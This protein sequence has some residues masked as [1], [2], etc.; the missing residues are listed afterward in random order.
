MYISTIFF[1]YEKLEILQGITE[2]V[3]W[4]TTQKSEKRILL[5]DDEFD[6]T[7]TLKQG[8]ED[9]GF[10]V[11]PFNDPLEALS[12]FRCGMYDL[13]L[14]DIRMP[15][16]NG[17]ELYRKLRKIDDKVKYCFMTA[18]EV[19]Y[20]TLKKDYPTLDIGCFIRKPIKLEELVL[21]L[22][23]QLKSSRI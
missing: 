2:Q 17:F 14:I 22:S 10:K 9:R 12:Y 20:Q 19:Y 4:V 15:H 6:I 8:L 1:V 5:V 11:D 13:A 16:M 7:Y 21:E 23:S 18:Y 3:T